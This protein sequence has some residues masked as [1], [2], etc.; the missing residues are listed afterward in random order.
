[1]CHAQKKGQKTHINCVHYNN[2]TFLLHYSDKHCLC[3]RS[4]NKMDFL[5]DTSQNAEFL[6]IQKWVNYEFWSAHKKV[7]LNFFLLVFSRDIIRFWKMQQTFKENT[8]QKL[9]L[10]CIVSN[11]HF[12]LAIYQLIKISPLIQ[13]CKQTKLFSVF[14]LNIFHYY[15]N[16]CL[17]QC[18]A[19]TS[20]K[21]L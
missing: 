18:V 1:M 15:L 2:V 12:F 10:N 6:D 3:S 17:L 14:L 4:A 20:W 21:S 11:K 9:S 5:A 19:Y 8:L 16:P 13:I 7:S